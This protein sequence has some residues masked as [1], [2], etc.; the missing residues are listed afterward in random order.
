MA[1]KSRCRDRSGTCLGHV[2]FEAGSGG[3]EAGPEVEIRGPSGLASGLTP[4][5]RSPEGRL[6]SPALSAAARP[7]RMGPGS[8]SFTASFSCFCKVT[9]TWPICSSQWTED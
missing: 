6:A 7:Q 5:E 9:D 2:E 4:W 8:Y 1:G 3:R